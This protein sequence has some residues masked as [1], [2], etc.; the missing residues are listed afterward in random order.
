MRYKVIVSD[1]H[2]GH[3]FYAEDKEEAMLLFNMARYSGMFTY[4]EVSICKENCKVVLDWSY[5]E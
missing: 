3:I 2:D 4:A 1:G 5:A